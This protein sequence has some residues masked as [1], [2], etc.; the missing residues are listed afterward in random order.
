MAVLSPGSN[1]SPATLLL[2]LPRSPNCSPVCAAF[3]VVG[4]GRRRARGCR[5]LRRGSGHSLQ[6]AGHSG[7]GRVRLPL[8]R[9]RLRLPSSRRCSEPR[10]GR[11]DRRMTGGATASRSSVVSRCLA[12]FRLRRWERCSEALMVSVVPEI[13]AASR[14]RARSRWTSFSAVVVPKSRPSCT[15]ESVVLTPW[16][17]GPEARE[18]S[19]TNSPA[20][21]R[22]PRGAPGLG[23]TY[24]SSTQS[25]CRNPDGRRT[26]TALRVPWNDG[27]MPGPRFRQ[28]PP[29]P[30]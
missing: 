28:R 2:R 21:T 30:R 27:G 22:R 11:V 20:G 1:P 4:V 5:P 7:P 14:P 6:Q 29:A 19:S 23:G 18:N 15:R 10:V 12:A 17:P 13:L 24:R 16:P 9:E 3:G 25:V 26:L 8:I